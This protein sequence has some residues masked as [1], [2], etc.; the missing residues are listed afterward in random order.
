MICTQGLRRFAVI[1]TAVAM[2]A[3]CS[4]N[5]EAAP[6][7]EDLS[8]RPGNSVTA[9]APESTASVSSTTEALPTTTSDAGPTT[10][11]E[12]TT[13]PTVTDD[14]PEGQ[15]TAAIEFFEDQWRTCLNTIP[16]CDLDAVTER[17]IGAEDPRTFNA[18]VGYN[19]SGNTSAGADDVQYFVESVTFA[20]DNTATTSMCIED[21]VSLFAADGSV[22]DDRFLSSKQT[23]F[24]SRDSE[25]VWQL[26]DRQVDSDFVEGQESSVCAAA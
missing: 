19:S 4:G 11:P 17:R 6:T 26:E 22:V 8:G 9:S 24:L 15:V 18:A 5:D 2:V 21:G 23:W 14:T 20:D 16:A 1:A 3:S 7:T 12:A 25:G 10:T 13:S